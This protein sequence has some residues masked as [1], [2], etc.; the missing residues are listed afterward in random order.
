LLQEAEQV[1]SAERPL[2]VFR[3]D[4][5]DKSPRLLW[6]AGQILCWGS[7]ELEEYASCPP[8]AALAVAEFV[9][10]VAEIEVAAVAVVAVGV[11]AEVVPVAAVALVVATGF[12]VALVVVKVAVG[13]AGAVVATVAAVVLVVATGFAVVQAVVTRRRAGKT[14]PAAERHYY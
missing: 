1:A 3:I 6:L 7:A 9:A 8:V 11:A 5:G 14:S 13:L 10:V 4:A 2:A 12:A